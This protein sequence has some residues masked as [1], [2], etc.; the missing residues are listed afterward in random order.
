M[1]SES[2]VMCHGEPLDT[3]TT[4]DVAVHGLVHGIHASFE[5]AAEEVG[6]AWENSF[7]YELLQ[8]YEHA[9]ASGRWEGHH[10]TTNH[11]E[12]FAEMFQYWSGTNDND[13]VWTTTL[14]VPFDLE[15]QS[16]EL[17]DYDPEVAAFL[18]R[19]FGA[20]AV[21]GSCHYYGTG[22]DSP[23]SEPESEPATGDREPDSEPELLPAPPV[24][25]YD[26]FYT[27]HVSCGGGGGGGA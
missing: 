12:Y 27:Q 14:D 10:A 24:G 26:P 16:A 23:E 9:M 25:R 18:D 8:L 20:V 11:W 22:S 5:L 21:T 6:I 19:H 4:E 17:A 1:V 3:H 15:R 13:Y 7:D 2:N